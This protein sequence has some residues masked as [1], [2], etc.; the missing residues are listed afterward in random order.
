MNDLLHDLRY[1]IR[2]MIRAR[3]VTA[4][5]VFAIALGI[6]ANTV[7]FSVVN[8]TLIKSLPYPQPDRIIVLF[9]SDLARGSEEAIAAANFIDWRDRNS[10]FEAMATYR[11]D[12]FTLT[13][14]DKPERIAGVIATAGLFPALGVQPIMGRV[15]LPEDENHGLGRVAVIS[16]SLWDRRFHRDP[17]I[18]GQKFLANDEPLTV[19]GVMPADF[20]YPQESDLW[21][22]PR[23]TVPEHQLNPD[24]DMST[25]R[26]THYLDS[27]GRLKPGVTL[28][29]ARED[30]KAVASQIEELNP[31]Q[32]AG[33]GVR[34]I[35]LHDHLVGDTK[36]TLLVLFG[37]VGFVLLI[38][39]SNV[40]NLLLAQAT[41]R[42]KEIAIRTA[43][44]AT[45]GRILRQLL[46]ESIS[47]STAGGA[48]GLILAMWGIQ[49]AIS[50]LPPNMRVTASIPVDARV[51]FFT[52]TLALLT[53][54]AFGIIPALQVS[55]TDLNESLKDGGRGGSSGA[56]R[57]R[58]RSVLI[59]SEIAL[60]LVLLTGAGLM[61]RSFLVLERVN[62]GFDENVLTMRLAIPASSYPDSAR[63]AAFVDR[64]VQ[65]LAS[66]PGVE[67]AGAISRLP[68]TPGNSS[69][70][71]MIDGLQ[72]NSTG[73]NADYRVVT[74]N[75]FRTMGIPLV[76]GRD[77]SAT[78]T[79]DAP[80][81][82]I[83]NETMANR[84]WPDSDAVGRR[85]SIAS[86]GTAPMEIVGVVGDVKHFGLDSASH[87]ELYTTYTNDAWP[88]MTAVVRAGAGLEG[89]G[90]AMRE[91]VWSV[92]R[93]IPVP[94]I[95]TT[96]QLLSDSVGSRRFNML[97]LAG[98]G[99]VALVLASIGI[100]GV[101]SYSVTQRAHEIGIRMALGARQTDVL[102]LVVGQGLSLA[103]IGIVIGLAASLA[104]TR[105]MAGLLFSVS[106]TDPLTLTVVSIL[107]AGI[108]LGASIVPARRATR[109]DPVTALRCE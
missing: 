6:A 10:V 79:T 81:V 86:G 59:V 52:A 17:N 87:P 103:L 60:S 56:K 49:G 28:A 91:A 104:L 51:L 101:I 1:G 95:R 45:R 66:I 26:D 67:T 47:L 89:I 36:T 20:R 105:V 107:L 88:T 37:A 18:I 109:V 57:T 99:G 31:N 23:K 12:G 11:E 13:G 82:A 43:L 19:V 24:S 93:D 72:A 22:P 35:G 55:R 98:F 3:A 100:Y 53:G 106:P 25:R 77:F 108:A 44:G 75:Y 14:A 48:I 33:R 68:L 40:A 34:L 97:L 7:I 76:R 2:M 15:F 62:P 8:A 5:A 39:C 94:A 73:A 63:K 80:K 90:D 9:E 4:I 29:Q 78:D 38:A 92:D 65:N 50:I 83:I 71:L 70:G 30:M 21:I 61:I 102:K 96:G 32:N 74:P 46:T 42:Q 85:V 69:R 41:A 54:L 84:Y 58:A 64:I 16:S 27:I